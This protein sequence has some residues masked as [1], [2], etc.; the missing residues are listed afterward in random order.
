MFSDVSLIL[1]AAIVRARN[2]LVRVAVKLDPPGVMYERL[3]YNTFQTLCIYTLRH[4]QISLK[5]CMS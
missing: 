4:L 1:M 2:E 5:I 3:V